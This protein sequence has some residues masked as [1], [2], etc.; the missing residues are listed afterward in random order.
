MTEEYAFP[1]PDGREWV[2]RAYEFANEAES[3]D[4]WEKLHGEWAGSHGNFSIWRT[5][6]PDFSRWLLV[7]CGEAKNLPMEVG[8]TPFQLHP[9]NAMEFALRRARAGMDAFDEDPT[10]E[11][12]EQTTRYGKDTPMTID[13][14]TGKVR[15]WH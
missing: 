7:V 13:P 12:F 1:L 2:V 14:S 10:A 3:A 15:P 6:D 9:E 4:A 5:T 11:W 8:G